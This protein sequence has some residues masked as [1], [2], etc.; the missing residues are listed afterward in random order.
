MALRPT[1]AEVVGGPLAP[2]PDGTDLVVPIECSTA[3]PRSGPYVSHPLVLR[4]D[5][6][7]TVPHDLDAERVAAAFGGYVTC[8]E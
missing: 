8:L 7:A 2:T 4:P 5:W 1:F 3:G 6:T